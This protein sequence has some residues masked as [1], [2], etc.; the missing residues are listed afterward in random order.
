MDIATAVVSGL[1]AALFLSSAGMK[2][3]SRPQ[4]VEIRDHLGVAPAQWRLIGLLEL[5]GAAGAVIGLAV[6]PLGVAATGGLVLVALGAITTHL[7][8]GDPP[9]AVAPAGTALL[10]AGG[11]LALQLATA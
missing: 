6:R 8:A 7:R 3:A 2:L 5:A 11:A 1:L 9:D 10:L 4:S